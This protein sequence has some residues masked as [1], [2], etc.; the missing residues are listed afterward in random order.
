[1]LNPTQLIEDL[2]NLGVKEDDLIIVHSSYNG[3]RGA[4][5]IE[6]GPEA[7][8]AALKETVKK[9]TLVI[10]TFSYENVSIDNRVFDVENTPVCIGILPETMRL[11]NDV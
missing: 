5:Q 1:M 6:G 4:D 11:S 8:I 10:P 7:V 9:G 3:L 2:R